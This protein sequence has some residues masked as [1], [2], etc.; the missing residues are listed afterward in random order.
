MSLPHHTVASSDLPLTLQTLGGASLVLPDGR[1][2]L[3]QGKPL[4]LLAYLASSPRRAA[5]REHLIDLL[6]ADVEPDKARHALRQTIWYLRQLLGQ[7]IV[8]TQ[9]DALTLAASVRVD[10]DAF[11]AAIEN[12]DLTA[13]TTIYRGTFL[14]GFAA[15]GGVEF[16]HWADLERER[17]RQTF[18]RAAESVIRA[19]LNEGHAREALDLARRAHLAAP[20]QERAWRLLFEAMV[21]S[22]DRLALTLEADRFLAELER[23]GRQPEPATRALLEQASVASRSTA[24]ESG[25][26]TLAGELVGR[27]REFATVLQAWQ[28]QTGPHHLHITAGAGL[29]KTRLLGD[30][31]AR[32][33][34]LGAR[35]V[36]LR[37]HPGQ[38]GISCSFAAELVAALAALP[39]AAGVSPASAGTLV[40]LNPT[41]SARFSAPAD[42]STGEDAARRRAAA[43][44][45]LFRTVSEE[46]RF[47]LLLDDTHWLDPASRQ[48]LRALLE[49][50]TESRTLIVTASRLSGPN[51]LETEHSVR[52]ELKP[53]SAEQTGQLIASIGRLPDEA[54]T[55]SLPEAVTR[56]AGGTPLLVLETLQLALER[57][58]LSLTDQTWG[59]P[60]PIALAH[61]LES[62][63]ALRHRVARLERDERWLLLLL[64]LAGTPLPLGGLALAS[65]RPKEAAEAALGTLEQRGVVMRSGEEWQ[66]AHDEIS[67]ESESAATVEER[68]AAHLGLGRMYLGAPR[69]GRMELRQAGHHL[70]LAEA[71]AELRTALIRYLQ[72]AR[73][74]GDS[75]RLAS[76]ADDFLEDPS[77]AARSDLFRL[78]GRLNRMRYSAARRGALGG[79]LLLAIL[80]MGTVM[81]PGRTPDATL[82]GRSVD[83]TGHTIVW[84]QPLERDRWRGPDPLLAEPSPTVLRDP[85]WVAPGSNFMLKR[86]GHEE[87]AVTLPVTD[88]GT[89]DIYLIDRTGRLGRLTTT[90]LDDSPITWSP[91]GQYLAINTA[92]WSKPDSQDYDVAVLDP[93]GGEPRRIAGGPEFERG[94]YWS[95]DG[96]RIAYMR[97]Y[98]TRVQ[99]AEACWA[100]LDAADGEHC[101]RPS[102]GFLVG[103]TGWTDVDHYL[104]QVDSLGA[105]LLVRLD[106]RTGEMTV[107]QHGTFLAIPSPDGAWIASI[108]QV[109]GEAEAT[110]SIFP[111]DEPDQAG[112]LPARLQQFH[113]DLSWAVSHNDRMLDTLRITNVPARVPFGVP[114]QLHTISVGPRGT[115]LSVRTPLRWQTSDSS[116][117]TVD[118]HGILRPWSAGRVSVTVSAGGWRRDSVDLVVVG[119]E[120]S[121][122][123][124][125]TWGQGW[126]DRWFAIGKPAP[127]VV[128]GPG[129]RPAFW[130]NGDGSY[131][132]F[133]ISKERWDASAGLGV[134]IDAVSPIN[135]VQW[136]RWSL[137]LWDVG[138]NAQIVAAMSGDQFPAPGTTNAARI[139]EVGYPAF[140]GASGLERWTQN[141]GGGSVKRGVVGRWIRDTTWYRVRMEIL[142]DGRC[143]VAINGVPVWISKAPLKL[144]V[145][146]RL[147]LGSNA[148]GV[149]LLHGPLEVWQGVKTD[150]DWSVLDTLDGRPVPLPERPMRPAASSQQSG[151]PTSD[152][153]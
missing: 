21:Q 120:A 8:L 105:D 116:I 5:G 14:D 67:A 18:L 11:L 81:W 34:T 71:R 45:E 146:L 69:T 49:Q 90:P 118:D 123:F 137:S 40:A 101:I 27:E 39:G 153:P 92:R 6:W 89:N 57:R 80:L 52:V 135:R 127:Q 149:R 134:E 48:V 9:G 61:G 37:V 140:E 68:R 42:S 2:L 84:S 141:G 72:L 151:H 41:L 56:A 58:W 59:C 36:P 98:R 15:P 111:S 104:A 66:P 46:A 44:I 148:A 53:L 139:C 143:G 147:G 10:R 33:R 128:T 70:T 142:P 144:D 1:Q 51:S 78:M 85:R 133:G 65:G 47:A 110:V 87:W 79:I 95:P 132:N 99:P 82:Y 63:S 28:R 13:A 17:L 29:G 122:V 16:E 150:I 126:Q 23:T 117:A 100:T 138:S 94:G 108:Q 75:R 12:G 114:T 3:G 26:A 32:L 22:G 130:N 119:H 93:E 136:Q 115:R 129:G 106:A 35:V 54:W 43:L 31:G 20:E 7:S 109:E 86:P 74:E 96:T 124:R 103:I 76:L 55:R 30:V 113:G 24:G 38:R 152:R 83:S 131:T 112:R 121:T 97:E 88:G 60:D 62:G 25:P 125:E 91:D 4:A 50:T 77:P 73:Q 102:V 107:L 64:A 19:W 145:P